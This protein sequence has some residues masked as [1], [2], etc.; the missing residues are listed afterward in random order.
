MV[1]YYRLNSD[2]QYQLEHLAT[3]Y[4]LSP[5]MLLTAETSGLQVI[6]DRVKKGIKGWKGECIKA[7]HSEVQKMSK[8]TLKETNSHI[9]YFTE[10]TEPSRR[11][12]PQSSGT[13]CPPLPVS[14][15]ICTVCSAVTADELC[16]NLEFNLSTSCISPQTLSLT[17][18]CCSS[19]PT[20]SLL[21][22]ALSYRTSHFRRQLCRL[23]FN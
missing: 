10:K 1:V 5:Q 17:C 7:A 21:H 23:I 18:R 12:F 9:S 6:S 14:V 3:S 8:Q 22:R 4:L 13:P 2:S 16:F 11:D 20:Q 19:D 15:L